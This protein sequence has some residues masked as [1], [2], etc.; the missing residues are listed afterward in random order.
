MSYVITDKGND[1]R[2]PRFF[3]FLYTP[4]GKVDHL[5][6]RLVHTAE[7]ATGI[8]TLAEANRLRTQ[9]FYGGPEDDFEVVCLLPECIAKEIGNL[10]RHRVEILGWVDHA[11]VA[12]EAKEK[13]D[14]IGGVSI[15][16]GPHSLNGVL[17]RCVLDKPEDIVELLRWLGAKGYHQKTEPD[18]YAELQRRTWNLGSIKVM[19]FFEGEVCKFVQV[20]EEMKPILELRCEPAEVDV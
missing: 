19:G 12:Q 8:E 9:M 4:E 15:G 14:F 17:I 7:E 18:D 3:E 13:F 1:D 16:W 10:E 11:N 6:A 20:G 2:G 5:K